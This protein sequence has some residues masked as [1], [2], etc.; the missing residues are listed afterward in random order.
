MGIF[1]A[2]SC[3]YNVEVKSQ[4]NST[5]LKRS[6]AGAKSVQELDYLPTQYHTGTKTETGSPALPISALFAFG[7][8]LEG[9]NK[10]ELDRLLDNDPDGGDNPAIRVLCVVGKGCWYYGSDGWKNFLA[11]EDHDEVLNFL[12]GTSNTIPG[13]LAAKGQPQFGDYINNSI[14]GG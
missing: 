13:F 8:D 10:T 4:L 1:P 9:D 2:E 7:S 3:L 6:I 12:A 14:L 11:T 5:E